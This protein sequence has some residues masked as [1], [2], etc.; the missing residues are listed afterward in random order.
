MSQKISPAVI[1]AYVAEKIPFGVGNA[2]KKSTL[3]YKTGLDERTV[4][5]HIQK[6]VFEGYLIVAAPKGGYYRPTLKDIPYVNIYIAQ[7][8]HREKELRRKNAALNKLIM[9]MIKE[10]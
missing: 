3:C 8:M 2:V 1:T 9:K 4:R 5:H 6:A 10:D 7:G